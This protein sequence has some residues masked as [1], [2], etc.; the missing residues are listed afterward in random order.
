MSPVSYFAPA[1]KSTSP[2]EKL[3]NSFEGS[4]KKRKRGTN[5]SRS[6]SEGQ[7][8]QGNPQFDEPSLSGSLTGSSARRSA[9]LELGALSPNT[10]IQYKASEQP[11]SGDLSRLNSRHT[12]PQD[13]STPR[14]KSWIVDD[15][16]ALKPPLC[17]PTS[18]KNATVSSFPGTPGLRQR[19]LAVVT[20]ILHR[21]VLEGDYIRAGRAWGMLLRAEQGG[22]STD[23]RSNGRW[24]LG[25][26]ILLQRDRQ[27]P[28]E[29]H[30]IDNTSG[31]HDTSEFIGEGGTS[32][33]SEGFEKAKDYYERL[34]LQYPYR[35]A[36]PAATGPPDFYFAM[37]GLWIY[38][39]QEQRSLKLASIAK[40]AGEVSDGSIS[41]SDPGSHGP[42][43]REEIRGNTLQRAQ[44]IGTCLK[45]LLL[46]PPYSDNSRFQSL[47][48]MVTLWISDLSAVDPPSQI[49]SDVDDDGGSST[50]GG[51]GSGS[52]G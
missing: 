41:G 32:F 25:A 19:H 28:K 24:G 8:T 9:E 26:E 14:A 2:F 27:L 22:H 52:L 15:L 20:V 48:N 37:F 6:G 10:A 13:T 44:E 21:C 23:L 1:F 43:R 49:G 33:S 50:R 42:R 47:Q 11:T 12:F 39:V 4:S 38:T 45:E 5:I 40:A 29:E 16:A 46:S 51:S 3:S 30:A 7:D 17:S 31:Q 35:K 34:V 36:F 18:T